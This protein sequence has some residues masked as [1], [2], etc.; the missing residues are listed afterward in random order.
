VEL[1]NEPNLTSEGL[2]TS[3]GNGTEFAGWF[4]DV[5][6]AYRT[7]LPGL[8]YLYPGLSPGPN[9]TWPGGR[10]LSHRLFWSDTAVNVADGVA[11]HSYWSPAYP[12][13]SHPDAGFNLVNEAI[14][15][16]P[17]KP[18]WITEASNNSGAVIAAQKVQEYI[19]FWCWLRTRPTVQGVTYFVMSA[20]NPAWHWTSG[21]GEVWTVAMATAAGG[22]VA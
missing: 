10:R 19:E 5:L 15:R 20:S 14:A 16:W 8:R 22:R 6:R 18:I 11:V 7:A 3:W 12:M 13:Q 1:H 21:S 9:A 2:D 4:M 17:S